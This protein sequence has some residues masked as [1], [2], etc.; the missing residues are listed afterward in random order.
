MRREVVP[1]TRGSRGQLL[2]HD[3][4][5]GVSLME[6]RVLVRGTHIS[7]PGIMA[8]FA[9]IAVVIGF[10]LGNHAVAQQGCF[11]V[12]GIF[13]PLSILLFVASARRRQH[14]EVTPDGFR[15]HELGKVTEYLDDEVEALSI[16]VRRNSTYGVIKSIT[17]KIQLWLSLEQGSVC[18]PLVYTYQVKN[19][20]PL[21]EFTNRLLHALF[22]DWRGLLAEEKSLVGDNWELTYDEL[23][24]KIGRKP[25]TITRDELEAVDVFG[26][27]LCVWRH[28][29]EAPVIRIPLRGKHVHLLWLLLQ[30]LI[31]ARP[32]RADRQDTSSK[33]L[34]RLL[35]ERGPSTGE[36]VIG[37]LGTMIFLLLGLAL[38][39]VHWMAGVAALVLITG[40]GY[41]ATNMVTRVLRCHEFGISLNSVFNVR[42]LRYEEVA[43]FT[44]AAMRHIVNGIYAGTTLR[45]S[46]VPLP[47]H[48]LRSITYSATRQ[49]A[50]LD[51]E[52]LREH[53]AQV[54]SGRMLREYADGQPVSWTSNLTFVPNALEYRADGIFG[55]RPPIRIPLSAIEG[56]N[57]DQGMFYI[58][59][60]DKANAIVSQ[61][62][63][64]P[65][66]FPG[67]YL[68]LTLFQRLKPDEVDPG[69]SELDDSAEPQDA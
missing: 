37:C 56:I 9:L 33:S 18:L 2:Y 59:T 66:F 58:W 60:K 57:T 16:Q 65:N 42:M 40:L 5:Y 8:F 61:A 35:F 53:I 38:F 3:K 30:D 52:L 69:D 55:K 21:A 22:E 39:A 45:M 32:Q 49:D 17:N 14:L 6:K 12:A 41:L 1:P 28:G 31:A 51:L 48:G 20:D 36:R 13:L 19:E 67:Y 10:Q 68:L 25:A 4:L 50:D 46:L 27:C 7:V 43:I 34:G 15:I 63:S 44:F 11:I 54:I 26:D 62:V 24:G 23:R 29:Q 64:A 47:E